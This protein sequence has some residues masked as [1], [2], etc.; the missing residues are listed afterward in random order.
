V[1]KRYLMVVLSLGLVIAL[2]STAALATPKEKSGVKGFD[3]GL[4]GDFPYAPDQ[5]VKAQNLFDELNGERLAFVTHDGDIKS[6]STACTGSAPRWTPAT[7]RSSPSS[8]R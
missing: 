6:G 2:A 7:P 8:R 5:Q 4:I 3:I 1:N